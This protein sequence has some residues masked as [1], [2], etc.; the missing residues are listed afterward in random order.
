MH[1]LR[2]IR[3]THKTLPRAKASGGE[4]T[5]ADE[6]RLEGDAGAGV[7]FTVP[8]EAARGLRAAVVGGCDA[9]RRMAEHRYAAALAALAAVLL[10][11]VDPGGRGPGDAV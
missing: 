3:G 5:S 9:L 10:V 1:W 8:A 4:P 6:G 7:R 2:T 11:S